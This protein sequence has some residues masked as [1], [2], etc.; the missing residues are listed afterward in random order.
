[1]EKMRRYCVGSR[2]FLFI[3]IIIIAAAP[4]AIFELFIKPQGVSASDIWKLT[5]SIVQKY[6]KAMLITAVIMLLF[7]IAYKPRGSIFNKCI[8]KFKQKGILDIVINDFNNSIILFGKNRNRA[9]IGQYCI[10]FKNMGDIVLFDEIQTA[11]IE[12]VKRKHSSGRREPDCFYAKICV[13]KTTYTVGQMEN[14]LLDPDWIQL[15]QIFAANAPH[16]YIDA[17]PKITV[18][19]IYDNTS[20]E[21]LYSTQDD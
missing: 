18:Q 15:Q 6:P 7:I 14:N 10:F 17:I 19:Y 16:I 13:G 8:K 20:N 9:R 11:R 12:I 1:M 4:V 21:Y 3:S 5:S 2:V